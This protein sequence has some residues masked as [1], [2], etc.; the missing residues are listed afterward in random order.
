VPP[1]LE[2]DEGETYSDK[3]LADNPIMQRS[4]IQ[5]KNRVC[6]YYPFIILI[7]IDTFYK[8]NIFIQN[9]SNLF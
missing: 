1:W 5:P 2:H 3:L 7:G 8:K 4:G 9:F 6:N